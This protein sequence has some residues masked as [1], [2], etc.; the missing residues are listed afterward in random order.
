MDATEARLHLQGL[1]RNAME[2]AHVVAGIHAGLFDAI[3]G[4]GAAGLRRRRWRR[5]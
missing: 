3:A 5:S 4:H 2:F 1:G